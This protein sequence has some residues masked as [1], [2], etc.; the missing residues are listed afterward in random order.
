MYD[1]PETRAETDAEWAA[2]R[3][4]LRARSVDAPERL[5]RPGGDMQVLWRHPKLLLA[6]TCWGPMGRGLQEHVQLVGQPDYSAFEGGQ[7]ALYSSAILMRRTDA[8]DVGAPADG[9]A[10]LPLNDLLGA[11]FA[12]NASDSMSGLLALDRDLEPAGAGL[13]IFSR[14]LETGSHRASALA[15][16]E[17]R[18]DA[19]ALDCRTW[20]MFRRFE[21]DA[22]AAL[23]V[24]GWTAR[25]G[26]LPFITS[27]T[28]PAETVETLSRVLADRALILHPAARAL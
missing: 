27:R 8:G 9:R 21:P 17:G 14:M 25:S 22:A 1:W 16:A 24:A 23:R 19:C 2:L 5:T 10:V 6:Q 4:A 26:G 11:S 15:V 13:S 3:D 7:G 28:T 12:Y 18:A 20:A